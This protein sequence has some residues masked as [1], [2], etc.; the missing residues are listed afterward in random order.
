MIYYLIRLVVSAVAIAMTALLAPG[1]TVAR[2][3]PAVFLLLGLVFGLLNAFLRP[4][5]LL[6]TGRLVIVTMGGFVL[7]VNALLLLVLGWLMPNWIQIDGLL[8]ALWGGILMALVTTVLEAILGLTQ[9]IR[10]TDVEDSRAR[11]YGLDRVFF[12]ERNRMV[13]NLRIQQVYQIFWRY[14]LDIAFDKMPF[15]DFRRTMQNRFYRIATGEEV[16]LTVPAKARLMLQ[17]LGP[18]YVKMGQIIS[19][20][21]QALP[22]DWRDEMA[23]LQSNVPPFPS[24]QA[25]AIIA[26]ELGAPV[27][28]LFATFEDA[29][30]AAASTAQVHRA[31]LHTGEQVVVKVQRPDI[32]TAV[33][34][35]LGIIHDVGTVLER[36]T[37]WA[38]DYN[39]A[40]MADEWAKH[41]VD[42]LDYRN[43]AFNAMRLGQNMAVY[44]QIHVPAIYQQLCSGKVLTMEFVKGVK[45]TNIATI[46]A[47]GLDRVHLAEIFIRSVIKQLLFDGFFHGDP[48]PGNILV[49][50][51]TGVIIYLDCGMMGYL[52]STQRTNL[53]DLIF[54]LYMADS[55]DLGRVIVSLSTQ[56]KPVDTG[57]FSAELDRELTRQ[58]MMAADGDWFSRTISS[59]LELMQKHG[60]RL[61]K[62]LTMA[63]KAIMQAE[64]AARTLNPDFAIIDVAVDESRHLLVNQWDFDSVV[65][66]VKK[67]GIRTVKEVIRRIPTLQEATL[68][69]LEQY[70][71]GRFTLH[72]ET[73]ELAKQ[74]AVFATAMR[75][76]TVA[77]ILM[78]MLIGAGLAA[79]VGAGAGSLWPQVAAVLFM[80]ALLLGAVVVVRLISKLWRA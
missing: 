70:E 9:P 36:R 1:I 20:Q 51:E 75:W 45:I 77:L 61:N 58:S 62:D 15:A 2:D 30:L 73:D 43:E 78:G 28:Q 63:L 44:P 39:L 67:E 26:E 80:L 23:K 40:G 48:H 24:A 34:A 13:E 53:A 41:V 56:F 16:R 59:V 7:V 37:N 3:K 54:T 76:L 55:R 33:K 64:E 6:F 29:P 32:M 72:V 19:S 79:Q 31:T 10:A 46:D 49:N 60:L 22:L 38:R 8:A 25:R 14:G 57:A 42:E 21:A 68:K 5:V 50:P 65:D 47:G 52:D 35:D 12:G 69:W 11:W 4:L 18:I 74:V 27:E 66:S 71:S 17:E